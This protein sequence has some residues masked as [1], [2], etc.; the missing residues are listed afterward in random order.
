[1][2]LPS[3]ASVHLWRVRPMDLLGDGHLLCV[4]HHHRE[5]GQLGSLRYRS[6][7]SLKDILDPETRE[8]ELK[9]LTTWDEM[10][11]IIIDSSRNNCGKSW[12]VMGLG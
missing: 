9:Y 10:A 8:W 4:L 6:K 3:D 1:M 7:L 2:L 11:G 5:G 12:I